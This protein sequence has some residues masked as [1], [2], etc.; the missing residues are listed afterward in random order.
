MGPLYMMF[1]KKE[2]MPMGVKPDPIENDPRFFK[3]SFYEVFNS[4]ND[5]Q[6]LKNDLWSGIPKGIALK[7]V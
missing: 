4:V 7:K 1:R 6:T 2:F 5:L 3:K